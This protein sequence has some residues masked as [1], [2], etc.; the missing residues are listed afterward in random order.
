MKRLN[1]KFILYYLTLYVLISLIF[2][3]FPAITNSFDNKLREHFFNIRGEISTT[4]S[5]VIVNIDEKSLKQ[6]GQWPFGRDKMAQVL[7]N[8][9]NA[10]VGIIGLDIVFAE[11]DRISPHTMAKQ[12]EVKGNYLDHDTLFGNVIANTP[13]ILGYFFTIFEPNDNNAP[14]ISSKISTKNNVNT[15]I[16]AKGVISNISEIQDN[17]YSSGFFNA[18]SDES[19][20]MTHMPLLMNYQNITYS[21]LGLE[22]I[23]IARQ[24]QN[25]NLEYENK[26]LIGI[27]LDE[28]FI[29]TDS[30]GFFNINFRGPQ[31]TFK[32][33]SFADIYNNKFKEED[34]KGKIVLIGTTI[35]TLADLR[36]TVYDLAMP[37][38]EIHANLIDNILKQD[39]LYKPTWSIALDVLTIFSL[40][41]IL[42]YILIK[43]KPIIIFP[44][45]IVLTSSLYVYLY[46]LLFTQGIIVNLFFPI[47]CIV[48]TT[49][50]TTLLKYLEERKT[51]L[52]IKD[53]FAKKVSP[54][55]MND[56]LQKQD[57]TFKVKNRQLTVFFSDLRD[58][59][60]ISEKINNPEKLIT[61]LNQYMEPMTQ[62]II[63]KEGTVDKFIGDAIMAYW[64]A[65]VEC[66]NH[67]DAA[68]IT[69]LNQLKSL[70]KLN[71][72]MKIEYDL[73]LDIG[74]G[75]N[76][77]LCTVGEMGSQG[78][79]DYTIIGDNVNLASRVEG[80]TKFFG[81][82][83]I[84]TQHT[85][86]MLNE[87]F[88]MKE[89]ATVKVKGKEE[90][91]TLYEV[92]DT[93]NIFTEDDTT[94]EAAL[95]NY[96]NGNLENA[97]ELFLNLN[98]KKFS[99]INIFY[100]EAC[101]NYLENLSQNFNPIFDLDFK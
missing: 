87:S 29:P 43:L 54:A 53:K 76:S 101:K 100:I 68:V 52:F 37:G 12:L 23:S 34:I 90:P 50:L 45:V 6:L 32:Y 27:S 24:T 49:L 81:V 31:K 22:L 41:L 64:N 75:I 17:S 11:K 70:K 10:E 3:N 30:K 42:G 9:T 33:I 85:K 13:T 66:I 59:T 15:I 57:D 26:N 97:L 1:L 74:I 84:I 79:S 46:Q 16:K 80:L 35:T 72:Q 62:A 47:I 4:N 25:I 21:S 96:K 14:V 56:L 8:L 73:E 93:I 28:F 55:V 7:I 67:A 51:S 99:K 94:Y 82:K 86:N 36:A 48:S 58:F 39:F 20:K 83:L 95:A 65:P 91:T 71:E 88:K 98:K 89:L 69:A 78:R 77:G 44:F 61:L 60:K 2:F 18:F 19:G 63:E 5:V 40:T 38:V 92:I